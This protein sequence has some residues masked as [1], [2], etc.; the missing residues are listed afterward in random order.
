MPRLNNTRLVLEDMQDLESLN[1]LETAL[2]ARRAQLEIKGCPRLTDWSALEKVKLS[3]L[4]LTGIYTLPD[5]SRTE[6]Y[7]L[8][9]ESLDWLEDLSLLDGLDAERYYSNIELID[10]PATIDISPVRRLKGNVLKV[11]PEMRELAESIVE[12]GRFSRCEIEY[13]EGGWQPWNG[14]VKLKSLEDLD[15]LPIAALKHVKN[16]RLAGDR[17]VDWGQ[18]D[19]WEQWDDNGR[20][21]MLRERETQEMLDRG[22]ENEPVRVEAGTLTDLTRLANLTGLE[23]LEIC[24]QP[25]TSLD[26]IDGMLDLR[27][28]ELKACRQLEDISMLFTLEK[29]QQLCLYE[30][31]IHSIQGIQNLTMLKTLELHQTE[32]ADLSPLADCDLTEANRQN[33]L[34]LGFFSQQADPSPL[35]GIKKFDEIQTSSEYIREW[36]PHLQG[37]EINQLVINDIRDNDVNDL[38]MLSGLR[39]RNLRIDSITH[40]KSLHGL[41]D[42]LDGGYLEQLEILGCPRLTDFSALEGK[43]LDRLW[44]YGTYTIPELSGMDIGTLRLEQM[45]WVKDLGVLDSIPEDR[46][47][48]IELAQMD[49]LKDLTPLARLKAGKQ[50]A[51]PE[52]LLNKAEALVRSGSFQGAAIVDEDG[53]GVSNS[54]FSLQSWEELDELPDSVV[55][56][57]ESIYLAGDTLYD[58]NQY[59]I[60]DEWNG[61]GRDLYLH[62]FDTDSRTRI[63]TGSM[64]DLSRLSRLTGLRELLIYCQPLT[65]LDGLE[66]LKNLER[67]KIEQAPELT[68]M[69]PVSELKELR[70]FTLRDTGIRDYEALKN[71]KKL[72]GLWLWDDVSDISFLKEID[73]SNAY[74]EGGM[75]LYLQTTEETDMTPLEGI[76][77]FSYLQ[78]DGNKPHYWLLHVQNAKVRHLTIN[79]TDDE[80][81]ADQLPQVT[82]RLEFHSV[83]K[84]KDL[85]GLKGPGPRQIQLD[86]MPSMT[87]LNGLQGLIGEG[88]V[89]EL[90]LGAVPMLSDWSALEGAGLDSLIICGDTVY[91]PEDLQQQARRVEQWEGW[92]NLDAQ[93]SADSLEDLRNMPDGLL[94]QI[95]QLRVIGDQVYNYDRYFLNNRWDNKKRK[96]TAYIWDDETQE[97]LPPEMGDGI[98]LSLISRMTG[99]QDLK[100]DVQPITDLEALRPLKQLRYLTLRFCP[101]LEDLSALADLPE[102]EALHLDFSGVKSIEGLRGLSKLRELNLNGLAVTDLTPL[103][104]CDFTYA[105]Q[106]GGFNLMVDNDKIKDW[107]FLSKI[108]DFSGMW[109]GGV[110][111]TKWLTYVEGA[112]IRG[113]FANFQNQKQFAEFLTV[114]PEVEELH[115]Q[116]NTRITDI[117]MLPELKN[118]RYVRISKNMNK[119]IRSLEGKEYSFELQIDE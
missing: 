84:L 62:H 60:Q 21:F 7:G 66:N 11:Q 100:L 86:S 2:E 46:E 59:D 74:R 85:T 97:E 8:R 20:Y 3:W 98:D 115:I 117:S 96:E 45:D 56:R 32:V 99:L 13:P 10:L 6:V 109:M 50:I 119:A 18:Y 16:L 69:G 70:D 114:H 112:K 65:S 81:T 42:M 113:I 43:H 75:D 78:M 48:S 108:T 34:T 94:E 19:L 95:G 52:N 83:R 44:L 107:S 28:V 92:W 89:R 111:P 36:L 68:D 57:I 31:P 14:E 30:V 15:R 91:L 53:W 37:A 12:E 26:G 40:L 9:I 1:G 25:L 67:L 102:L 110:N 29:I 71:A 64:H 77:E 82:E 49:Q 61:N 4:H 33:G 23:Q 118:L 104:D 76:R 39:I 51:V 105:A 79:N 27:E 47:L 90:A 58:Q 54:N 24:D 88:G 22:E 73:F 93:L 106:N 87:S 55:A 63:K 72:R 101:N 41:E 103:N 80:F 17:I 5:L 35:E 38:T 116:W